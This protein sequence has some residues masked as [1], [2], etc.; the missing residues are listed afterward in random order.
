MRAVADMEDMRGRRLDDH[1]AERADV[2][3]VF[4]V[5][6]LALPRLRVQPGIG[7][8]NDALRRRFDRPGF[9]RAV[10]VGQEAFD[11]GFAGD[12]ADVA[13]ADAVG[14]DD[15]DALQA[16]QRLFRDQRRRENPD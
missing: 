12:L 3:L 2:A 6:I 4:V 8:R 10:I 13:A 9:R 11:G 16:Q 7:R 1:G 15:G 14:Q 5:E